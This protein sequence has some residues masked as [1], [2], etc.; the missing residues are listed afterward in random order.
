MSISKSRELNNRLKA[1]HN[2]CKLSDISVFC[3]EAAGNKIYFLLVL[4]V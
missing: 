1:M 2:H 3:S 4:K